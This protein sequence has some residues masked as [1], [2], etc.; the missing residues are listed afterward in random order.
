MCTYSP[1]QKRPNLLIGK[2][3]FKGITHH[4]FSIAPISYFGR[5]KNKYVILKL[6]NG[7]D[8]RKLMKKTKNICSIIRTVEAFRFMECFD[9]DAVSGRPKGVPKVIEGTPKLYYTMGS[10]LIQ[11]LPK[12]LY[13]ENN[14]PISLAITR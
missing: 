11:N 6:T 7:L 13:L 3:S 10:K 2:G 1:P 8:I 12:I 9:T 4:F 14:L 5:R